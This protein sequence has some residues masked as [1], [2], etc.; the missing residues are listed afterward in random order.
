MPTKF[1]KLVYPSKCTYVKD[2]LSSEYTE[3]SFAAWDCIDLI[4]KVG[5]TGDETQKA[6]SSDEYM[7]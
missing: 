1:C 4:L 7:S 3:I 2:Y 6:I 5:Y